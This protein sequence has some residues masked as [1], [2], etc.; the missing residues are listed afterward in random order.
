MLIDS[1][2]QSLAPCTP[3]KLLTSATQSSRKKLRVK[4][5]APATPENEADS[6][7]GK[8]NLSTKTLNNAEPAVDAAGKLSGNEVLEAQQE[9]VSEVK[10][11]ANASASI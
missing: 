3:L 11:A 4:D 5:T 1:C 2:I 7:L 9:A 6:E 8:V 10:P